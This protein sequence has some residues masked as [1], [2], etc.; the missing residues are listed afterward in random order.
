MSNKQRFN[1]N[2]H[3]IYD[4]KFHL[5]LVTK[6]RKKCLSLEVSQDLKNIVN[7]MLDGYGAELIDISTEPDHTHILFSATPDLHIYK[8][9]NNLKTVSSRLLRKKYLAYFQQYKLYT[10]LWKRGYCIITT[11]SS[12]IDI[13][14]KYLDKQGYD[15]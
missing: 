9:V 7:K 3:S 11:G 1:A 14:K 4:I 10:L 13:V 2:K 8:F 5:V 12:N 15:D 6:Y